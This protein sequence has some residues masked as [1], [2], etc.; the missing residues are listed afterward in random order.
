[1]H[2]PCARILAR[3]SPGWLHGELS[4]ILLLKA[5]TT[6]STSPASVI[7]RVYGHRIL[8]RRTGSYA[9]ARRPFPGLFLA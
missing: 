5:A 9:T 1:M 8:R 3:T 6:T 2:Q 4:L 7:L